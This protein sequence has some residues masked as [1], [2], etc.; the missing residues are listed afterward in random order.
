MEGAGESTASRDEDP[1]P[2]GA[3]FE[4][5][6]SGIEDPG[7]GFK[8]DLAVVLAASAEIIFSAPDSRRQWYNL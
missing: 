6:A 1:C 4:A 7:P 8:I 3:G 5:T 2:D